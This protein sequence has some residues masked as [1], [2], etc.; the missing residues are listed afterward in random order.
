MLLFSQFFFWMDNVA[1]LRV[2]PVVYNP[3]VP[4][5]VAHICSYQAWVFFLQTDTY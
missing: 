4:K 3:K 1:K 2:K 5:V